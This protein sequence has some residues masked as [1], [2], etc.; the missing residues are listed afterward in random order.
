[1]KPGYK[2]LPFYGGAALTLIAL[3]TGSG[4]VDAGLG[5]KIASV[6]ASALGALGFTAWRLSV[7]KGDPKK[8]FWKTS[9][10]WLSSAAFIVGVL[11]A[12]GAFTVGGPADKAL[13]LVT[14]LLAAAG[15]GVAKPGKATP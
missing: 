15:Y 14:M 12:S 1:M 11:Y 7:K 10:F 3:L 9:E 13:G 4:A 8:P 2:T 6:A 5:A